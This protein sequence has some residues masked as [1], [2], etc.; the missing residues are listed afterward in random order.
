MTQTMGEAR[1]MGGGATATPLR[2][3]PQYLPYL[4]IILMMLFLIEFGN[5]LVE[6]SSDDIM[7][8][9]ESS[10]LGSRLKGMQSLINSHPSLFLGMIFRVT[11][12]IILEI[13]LD[14]FLK[15]VVTP[16]LA[17]SVVGAVAAPLTFFVGQA[18]QPII[19]SVCFYGFDD[20]FIMATL[21]STGGKDRLVTL[22]K[23][24]EWHKMGFFHKSFMRWCIKSMAGFSVG[25]AG[26]CTALPVV[27][28]IL[29][30]LLS[31]W[32]VAWDMVYVPLSGMGHVGFFRQ[33]RTVLGNFRAFYWFGFTAVL[34]EEIPLAGPVCHVYNVYSAAFFLERVYLK[35]VLVSAVVG[36]EEL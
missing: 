21:D 24:G 10:T 25:F 27:G 9:N 7:S 1:K 20:T 5:A 16:F 15:L 26:L 19:H 18:L 35:E 12:A 11:I 17:A 14:A 31:G 23:S 3:H 32:V 33:L 30:A 34:I 13:N 36:D 8:D 6:A 29:T 4:M 2:W 28:P 22:S